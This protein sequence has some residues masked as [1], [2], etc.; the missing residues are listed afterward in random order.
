MNRKEEFRK[1]S[2]QL[3]AANRDIEALN[4]FKSQL[5]SLM[6]HRFRSEV[7]AVRG[8]M[9]L[10]L[11]ELQENLD[12]KVHA[13]LSKV[14]SS[15]A[16]LVHLVDALLD[17]RQ[18]EEG[19]QYL[20]EELNLGEAGEMFAG[21]LHSAA[22]DK[23][24]KVSYRAPGRNILV[25]ADRRGLAEVVR[26]ILDNAVKYTPKGEIV[27]QV[28]ATD[29]WGILSVRDTGIGIPRELLPR[30]FREFVRDER[31]RSEIPGAGLG[32]YISKKIV[33]AHR[34]EIHAESPGPGRGAA[35]HVY[36]PLVN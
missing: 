10:L 1:L 25:W 29:L 23:N 26:K 24:L 9:S 34:G 20:F 36:L 30:L 19:N 28:A 11:E 14:K 35:F 13:V 7:A 31:I 33:D 6:S 2:E 17:L 21:G 27:V 8:E 22:A 5:L 18:I 32:L 15:N 12:P 4:R 16:Q 3:A